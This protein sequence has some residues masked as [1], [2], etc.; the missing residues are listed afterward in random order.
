MQRSLLNKAPPHP[1]SDIMYSFKVSVWGRKNIPLSP[2]KSTINQ[3]EYIYLLYKQPLYNPLV[4]E[5]RIL[6]KYQKSH[7][8]FERICLS[9]I[10][11]I[12]ETNVD[13]CHF[14]NSKPLKKGRNPDFEAEFRTIIKNKS[15]QI[16]CPQRKGK[17]TKIKIQNIFFASHE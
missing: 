15:Y 6:V 3:W 17:I 8:V 13:R 1:P 12:A 16:S 11:K 14:Q 7:I 9:L 5:F 10:R 4:L 2:E